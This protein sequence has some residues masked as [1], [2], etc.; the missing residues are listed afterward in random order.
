MQ[1]EID[2]SRPI[3]I[4]EP[5]LLFFWEFTEFIIGISLMVVGIIMQSGVGFLLFGSA[6][7]WYLQYARRAA[8][9][10]KRGEFLHALWGKGLR[11]D[12]L[13]KQYPFGI[14]NFSGKF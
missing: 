4:D 8:F 7:V 2:F 14:K 1:R 11:E 10:Q 3:D 6:G 12:A 9:S 5:G 13:L